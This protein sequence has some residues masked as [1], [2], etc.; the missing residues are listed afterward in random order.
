[1]DIPCYYKHPKFKEFVS[2]QKDEQFEHTGMKIN[3]HFLVAGATGAG[4]SNFLVS[5]LAQ[6]S[7]TKH[8]TFKHIFVCYK[9]DEELY[10][11]LRSMIDREQISFYKS[12]AS[13]PSVDD[14]P[15]QKD[16]QYLIVFD[17]VI[18]DTDKK[19]MD[20]IRRYY[21]YGRKKN[22][23]VCFLG[24]SFFDVDTFIRKNSSYTILCHI[25][26]QRDL[27]LIL[28]NYPLG[29]VDSV[30]LKKMYEYATEKRGDNE[31]P[32]FKIDTNVAK[33]DKVFSRNFIDYIDPE[34]FITPKEKKQRTKKAIALSDEEE[35][36]EE[37]PKEKKPR[38]K[39]TA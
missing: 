21:C 25:N 1:M 4:K 22:L 26:G 8:G 20:K 11:G 39:K 7:L 33:P 19:S 35:E 34:K 29:D 10:D 38:K 18:N 3:R 17:D 36:P 14:F 13:F 15:D 12:V 28:R 9:T 30:A 27:N 5:Y 2:Q 31:M 24:Q 6:T 16:D 37:E 32:V 23:T